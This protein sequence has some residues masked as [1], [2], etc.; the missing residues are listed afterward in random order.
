MTALFWLA[1]LLIFTVAFLEPVLPGQV[2]FFRDHTSVFHHDLAQVLDAYANGRPALWDPYRLGGSPLA[3]YPKCFAYSP[4]MLLFL[5]PGDFYSLY[6]LLVVLHFPVAALSMYVLARTLR[7]E[8]VPSVAAAVCYGLSGPLVATNNLIPLLQSMTFGP[9]ALAAVLQLVER[10]T[11]LW[12]AAVAAV[13]PL[14]VMTGDPAVFVDSAFLF[15]ALIALNPPRSS[16]ALGKGL[17]CLAGAT[18]VAALVTAVQ[19]VPLLEVL[20]EST[21]GTGY[22]QTAAATFHAPLPR[23]LEFLL[24]NLNGDYIMAQTLLGNPEDGRIYFSSIFLGS[25]SLPLVLAARRRRA[26]ALMIGCAALFSLIAVGAATPLF[27][28]LHDLVPPLRYSRFPI[29]HLYGACVCLAVAVGLGVEGLLTPERE[30]Q[31]RHAKR[32][33]FGAAAVVGLGLYGSIAQ[34]DWI[35]A[36]LAPGVSYETGLSYLRSSASHTLLFALI[37]AGG[38]ALLVRRRLSAQSIGLGVF[39]ILGLDLA[40][41]ARPSVPTASEAVL[42]QV[43]PAARLVLGQDTPPSVFLY[44]HYRPPPYIP[45]PSNIETIAYQQDRLE[46]SA[47]LPLG[48]RYFFS[49]DGDDLLEPEWANFISGLSRLDEGERIR[50]LGRLG[51]THLLVESTAAAVPGLHLLGRAD[52]RGGPPISVFRLDST[53]GPVGWATRVKTAGTLDE[54]GA[55]VLTEENPEVAIMRTAE[56][57]ILPA[58]LREHLTSTSTGSA[59]PARQRIERL[60]GRMVQATVDAPEPGLV[61]FTQRFA[62][63]WQAQVNDKDVPVLQVDGYLAGVPVPEGHSSVVLTYQPQSFERGLALTLLGLTLTLI[64]FLLGLR[65]WRTRGSSPGHLNTRG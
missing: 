36:H 24:P 60:D 18:I 26:A 16:L 29:K 32:A 55:A 9:L 8:V 3:A 38:L 17:V 35:R 64:M 49:A 62:P 65:Q 54:V 45:K 47:G 11:W 48:I 50:V 13:M 4:S 51:V 53:R 46:W 23:L 37:G 12:A 56:L 39:V 44:R 25:S 40:V 42:N 41:A 14:H 34:P 5:L 33:L 43:P 28:V 52:T 61:I 59:A 7:L 57:A 19:V 20:T 10:R 15:V 6:D 21:R 30:A 31:V 1:G 27:G 63:G 22:E 2:L 58:K